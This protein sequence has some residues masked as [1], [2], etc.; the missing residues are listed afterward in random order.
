M[1]SPWR[2]DRLSIVDVRA[3][4]RR[5]R[6]PFVASLFLA[7]L[8]GAPTIAGPTVA[9]PVSAPL[10]APV[11][12]LA[13]AP[14]TVTTTAQSTAARPV[15]AEPATPLPPAASADDTPA[16]GYP[17]ARILA[18]RVGAAASAPRAPPFSA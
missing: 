1:R 8:L 3:A 17:G 15:I 7:A 9:H 11:A 16:V 14:S 6:L 2:L 18:D 5:T 4:L 13:A 10:P 12:V